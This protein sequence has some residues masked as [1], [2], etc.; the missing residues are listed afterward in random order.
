M[1]YIALVDGEP[2][3]YGVVFPDLPGCTAMG[4]TVDDAIAAAAS[5][6]NDWVSSVEADGYPVP[7]PRTAE[8]IRKDPAVA[9]ALAEGSSLAI[10]L[11]VRATGKPVRANLSLDEGIVEAIDEAARHRGVTRSGMVELLAREHLHAMA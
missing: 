5:S 10:I 2:G 3:A 7:K 11:L 6:L 8:E 1:R 9:E 4:D